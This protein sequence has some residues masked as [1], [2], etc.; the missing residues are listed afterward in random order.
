VAGEAATY[1]IV[2]DSPDQHVWA[3]EISPTSMIAIAVNGKREGETVDL[4]AT[5]LGPRRGVVL[6]VRHKY[7]ARY[8]TVLSEFNRRFPEE[9]GLW[10]MSTAEVTGNLTKLLDTRTEQIRGAMELYEQRRFTVGILARMVGRTSSQTWRTLMS[11][12]DYRPFVRPGNLEALG[13]AARDLERAR[14]VVVDL[15]AA[16]TLFALDLL[17][18]IRSFGL[19]VFVPQAV[20]DAIVEN[21]DQE[22]SSGI[23]R[24]FTVTF[25]EGDKYYHQEIPVE[26]IREGISALERLRDELRQ[27][28]VVGRPSGSP[29]YRDPE[30]GDALGTEFGDAV[31]VAKAAGLVLLSDDLLLKDLAGNEWGIASVSSFDL[32]AYGVS[33]GQLG[34]E[35]FER[36]TISMVRWGYRVVPIRSATVL[37]AL[38]G[39]GYEVDSDVKDLLA[40]LADSETDP[41]SAVRVAVVVLRELWL[42]PLLIHKLHAI[43]DAI[44]EALV[45]NRGLAALDQLKGGV[46]IATRLV[47]QYG[48]MLKTFIDGFGKQQ[49]LGRGSV[50]WE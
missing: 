40:V 41:G 28:A 50:L 23:D 22:R 18:T 29:V 37:S 12:R 39:S 35:V 49:R 8:Q 9:T 45:R 32:L 14:G 1:V 31:A 24:P 42:G 10:K 30:V 34:D 27:F 38:R 17:S 36:S 3:D 11:K 44:L 5:P 25:K 13:A 7:I 2:A 20:V 46:D 21:I 43:T 48:Q 16:I 6:T 19:E 26:Q 33:V 47:P 4:P 15:T